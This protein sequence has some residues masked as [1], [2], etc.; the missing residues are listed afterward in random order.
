[1]AKI[2]Q[3]KRAPDTINLIVESAASMLPTL[4]IPEGTHCC[5]CERPAE[6]KCVCEAW[7]CGQHSY[8]TN[9]NRCKFGMCADCVD[10]VHF[11]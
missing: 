4:H 5:D 1:M 7:I 10:T 8:D 11:S 2:L 3:W 6:Y 9:G